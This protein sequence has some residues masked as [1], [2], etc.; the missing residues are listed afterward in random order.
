MKFNVRKQLE[1]FLTIALAVF[2]LTISVPFAIAQT[3]SA[4]SIDNPIDNR[5]K[6]TPVLLAGEQLFVV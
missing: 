5:V 2:L 1:W 4:N 3:S 6:E